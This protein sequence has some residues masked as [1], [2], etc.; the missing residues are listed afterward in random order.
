[1]NTIYINKISFTTKNDTFIGY[2]FSDFQGYHHT[3][4]DFRVIDDVK[5]KELKNTFEF[6]VLSSNKFLIY[7]VNNFTN[8]KNNSLGIVNV[9]DKTFRGK[10]Q[11]SNYGDDV[12]LTYMLAHGFSR[13]LQNDIKIYKLNGVKIDV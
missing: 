11:F 2:Q 7:D 10:G 3:Y 9:I 1:M 8:G 12:R 5:F 4:I 13:V 6:K